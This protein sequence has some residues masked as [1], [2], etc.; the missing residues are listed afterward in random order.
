MAVRCTVQKSRPSSKFKVKGQRSR[1]PRK[2]TKKVRHFVRESSSGRGPRA[3]LDA[4]AATPVGKPAHAVYSLI[5]SKHAGE[6]DGARTVRGR[7]K[8]SFLF[9]CHAFE[10]PSLCRR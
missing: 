2:K 1:S 4:G 7:R 10:Q 3:A 6:Y 9:I 8:G 5:V